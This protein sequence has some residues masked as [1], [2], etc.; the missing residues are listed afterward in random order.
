MWFS[1]WIR[2]IGN[3]IPCMQ[4][5]WLARPPFLIIFR[6]LIHVADDKNWESGYRKI[7]LSKVPQKLRWNP[8]NCVFF[9]LQKNHTLSIVSQQYL[10]YEFNIQCTIDLLQDAV[11]PPPLNRK[12]SQNP[13]WIFLQNEWLQLFSVFFFY[14]KH[15]NLIDRF[16]RHNVIRLLF[17]S[18][19][20]QHTCQNFGHLKRTK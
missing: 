19:Y 9:F 11:L 17:E 14:K 15:Y 20:T 2:G 1:E 18:Y 4:Q 13:I 7:V 8:Q 5:S 10:L 6:F 3:S 16:H 12:V